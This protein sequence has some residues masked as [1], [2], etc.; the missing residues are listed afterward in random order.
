[1]GQ[2]PNFKDSSDASSP[3]SREWELREYCRFLEMFRESPCVDVQESKLRI[4]NLK[5]NA[6]DFL[7][8]IRNPDTAARPENFPSA[9]K[10]AVYSIVH[11]KVF[12]TSMA[13]LWEWKSLERH[14]PEVNQV[15]ST[16]KPDIVNLLERS[17]RMA[18]I[19]AQT[20]SRFTLSISQLNDTFTTIEKRLDE[21]S[22]SKQEDKAK[23]ILS[24]EIVTTVSKEIRDAVIVLPK[25]LADVLGK[26]GVSEGPSNFSMTEMLVLL[27][28]IDRSL[29][30]VEERKSSVKRR[31]WQ[32]HQ[33]YKSWGKWVFVGAWWI[34]IGIGVGVLNW[35]GT[36]YRRFKEQAA[37]VSEKLH[38]ATGLACL[39]VLIGKVFDIID[40][41]LSFFIV[42][43]VVEVAQL[44][45]ELAFELKG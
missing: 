42:F 21:W 12:S 1:M 3:T 4:R 30:V 10:L 28:S 40:D 9:E 45:V 31:F 34:G 41:E 24:S 13:S 14:I 8:W 26:T 16:A 18:Q 25:V 20:V 27:R 35:H 2:Y 6:Y 38:L 7:D 23:E 43:F 5:L 37:S 19:M 15:P 29:N 36:E 33:W 32:E 44:L 39:W 11:D 22:G 17:E